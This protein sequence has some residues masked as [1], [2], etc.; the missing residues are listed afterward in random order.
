MNHFIIAPV[1]LPA[2]IGGLI[3]LWMRHDMLLQRVFST[4]GSVI[5]LGVSLYL[6]FYA[7]S[8]EVFVTVSVTGPR[9]SASC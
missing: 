4:A 5:L 7:S 1:V 6:A 2:V 3:I 8:G 9:P